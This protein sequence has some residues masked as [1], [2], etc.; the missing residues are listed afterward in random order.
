[1]HR[2]IKPANLILNSDGQ[3]KLTD[4]GVAKAFA[5]NHLTASGGIVGT[6][7]YISPEQAAGK[8]VG[9]RSD[10][11]C[12]GCVL[13]KL[14]TGRPPFSGNSYVE[15]LHKHRYGQFDRPIKFIPDVPL[16]VDELIFHLL[17]KDHDKRP[18]DAQ[19]LH[20]QLESLSAKLDR[21]GDRT[22]VDNR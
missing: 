11:Y 8:V 1:I 4:F 10:L 15:L 3:I 21:Q 19:V 7:E 9:K 22:K 12:L 14:L 2:D 6:A 5:S 17:D 16:E 13:Y 18:R 20:K